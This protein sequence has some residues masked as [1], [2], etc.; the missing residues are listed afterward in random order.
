MN[1]KYVEWHKHEKLE[2]IADKIHGDLTKDIPIDIDYIIEAMGLEI[3][4]VSN[5]KADFGIFG[6]LGK[7]KGR[8]TILIQKGDLSLT[9]YNTSLTLAEELA[10]FILHKPL[11]QDVKNI[12]DAFAFYASVKKESKM[13]IEFNAKHLAGAILIPRDH[14]RQKALKLYRENREVLDDLLKGD[15]DGIID[16]LSSS[17]SDIYQAPQI[18]V[19]YRL[20]TKI[21]G[22]RESLKKEWLK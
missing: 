2:E 15:C 22:F 13:M 6:F 11:F 16:H 21:I 7:I 14:L 4:D 20:K 8:F 17:L 10:H 3:D 19:S 5:L 9:N 12:D 1:T 18:A